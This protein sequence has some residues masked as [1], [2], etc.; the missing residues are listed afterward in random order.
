ME[1]GHQVKRI[2]PSR[3][4]TF[5]LSNS[6]HRVIIAVDRSQFQSQGREYTRY[7]GFVQIVGSLQTI[8]RK[9]YTGIRNEK[10]FFYLVS[11]AKVL[12]NISI[13]SFD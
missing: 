11:L 12:V 13:N 5:S 9:V 2:A 7:F 10:D 4:Y 6:C 8:W 3:G 1:H